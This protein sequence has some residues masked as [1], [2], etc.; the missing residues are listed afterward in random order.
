MIKKNHKN[1]FDKD[2]NIKN[3]FYDFN[4]DNKL[5]INIKKTIDCIITGKYDHNDIL[6]KSY[7]LYIYGLKINKE[8]L[9][10]ERLEIL[11]NEQHKIFK[12]NNKKEI[13]TELKEIDEKK[14]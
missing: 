4:E 8:D 6:L 1:D 13:K 3:S 11:L 9:E 12:K 10:D 7:L 2:I 5:L 14:H